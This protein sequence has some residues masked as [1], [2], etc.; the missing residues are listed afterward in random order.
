MFGSDEINFIF[1]EPMILIEDLDKEKC[2]RAQEIIALFSQ[3]FF[4]YFSNLDRNQKIFWHGK[5]FSINN[6]KII[7]YIKYRSKVIKN[8]MTTYFLK[9]KNIHM[10]NIKM[11]ERE[12]KCLEFQDYSKLQEN[13]N[14]ILYF[15]G[16]KI[17]LE[18]YYA[19]NVEVIMQEK[20]KE[21]FVDLFDF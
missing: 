5:C 17:D 13:Q 15:N 19:G 20:R 7:S 9:G 1:T 10:G 4:D 8:V 11:Q 14:G 2:N 6:E 18:K 16:N 3:Y 12:R 21:M